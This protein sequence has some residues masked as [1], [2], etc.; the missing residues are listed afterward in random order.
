MLFSFFKTRKNRQFDY[1]PL[2]YQPESE[3]LVRQEEEAGK[4]IHFRRTSSL[5]AANRRSNGQIMVLV[6]MLGGL[7]YLLVQGYI[8]PLT[9]LLFVASYMAWRMGWIN[10]LLGSQKQEKQA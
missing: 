3:R 10:R 2:Y 8:D 1:Q 9:A 7:L 4:R 5:A 6:V